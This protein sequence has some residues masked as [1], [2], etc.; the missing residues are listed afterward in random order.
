MFKGFFSKRAGGL[1]AAPSFFS[2]RDQVQK[3]E[4]LRSDQEFLISQIQAWLKLKR[5]DCDYAE[6]MKEGL[7]AGFTSAW[8]Y[9]QALGK[10]E[11]FNTLIQKIKAWD[12]VSNRADSAFEEVGNFLFY[13]Q[14]PASLLKGSF[15]SRIDKVLNDMLPS[16]RKISPAEFQASFMFTDKEALAFFK[17]LIPQVKEKMV[18]LSCGA[19]ICG[20]YIDKKN[21]L[22]FYDSNYPEGE[23]IIYNYQDLIHHLR[24]SLFCVTDPYLPLSCNVFDFSEKKAGHYDPT[25]MYLPVMNEETVNR[26][27]ASTP[28]CALSLSVMYF[29]Y[30]QIK[31]L[32]AAG[33]HP[34]SARGILKA[35]RDGE[36]NRIF[37]EAIPSRPIF[38]FGLSSY[39]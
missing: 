29:Q 27:N 33:A 13:L 25:A 30:E 10:I 7:C 21:Y 11:Y 35:F 5:Y 28:Y 2:L 16:H 23:K 8:L 24:I 22:H 20:L 4:S 36:L 37:E 34:S 39:G 26:K 32:L 12:G 14:N 19:H 9:Y 38:G 15:Q 18:F 17:R 31:H 3:K 6:E 1:V